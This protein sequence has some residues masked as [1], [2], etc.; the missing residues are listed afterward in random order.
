MNSPLAQIIVLTWSFVCVMLPHPTIWSLSWN[1]H[2][3]AFEK[4]AIVFDTIFHAPHSNSSWWLVCKFLPE[5]ILYFGKCLFYFGSDSM[6]RVILPNA[7]HCAPGQLTNPETTQIL[8]RLFPFDTQNFVFHLQPS[9]WNTWKPNLRQNL[10]NLKCLKKWVDF[11][12]HFLN[13]LKRFKM[14]V[15][16]N[17]WIVLKLQLISQFWF[18]Q[19]WIPSQLWN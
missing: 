9:W 10:P 12:T 17:F 19:F 1:L 6:T 7:I 16:S 5:T 4:G 13:V 14:W 15:Q 11:S 18:Q 2:S 3:E 8:S